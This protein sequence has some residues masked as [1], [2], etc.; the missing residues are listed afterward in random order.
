[1]ARIVS[2]KKLRD[3]LNYADTDEVN[4]LLAKA[5]D[6]ATLYIE[7]ML[8]TYLTLATSV[9][10][11]F[12]YAEYCDY[13]KRGTLPA[14]RLSRGY[15]SSAVV[16]YSTSLFDWTGADTIASSALR[17]RNE[18]GLLYLDVNNINGFGGYVKVVYTAGYTLDQSKVMVG[19]PDWLAECAIIAAREL[20]RI[21]DMEVSLSSDLG[22]CGLIT[23][24]IRSYGVVVNPLL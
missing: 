6:A 5:L 15:V 17:L 10:D 12:D 21:D 8:K 9:E 19:V 1:M 2:V 23:P 24:H 14:L 4:A 13:L 22:I 11:V 18:A 20:Y 7:P 3:R 16:T